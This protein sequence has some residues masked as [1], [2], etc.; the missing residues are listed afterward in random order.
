MAEQL[1]S[2]REQRGYFKRQ[3]VKVQESTAGK[4]GRV[5][6]F[7]PRSDLRC[8]HRGLALMASKRGIDVNK[9]K[10]GEYCI[11]VNNARDKLKMYATGNTVAYLKMPAGE[12]LNLNVIAHIPRFFTGGVINYTAALKAQIKTDLDRVGT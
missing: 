11:F 1:V 2:P 7:F 6:R 10:P 12:K 8:Q 5:V 9:L 4:P 3:F